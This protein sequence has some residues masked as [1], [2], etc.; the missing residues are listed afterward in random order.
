[1]YIWNLKIQINSFDLLIISDT[2]SD[3][4]KYSVLPYEIFSFQLFKNQIVLEVFSI[5]CKV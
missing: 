4:E 3:A 2:D 5:C 1:M